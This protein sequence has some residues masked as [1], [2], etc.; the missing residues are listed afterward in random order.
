MIWTRIKQRYENQIFK[1]EKWKPD[2]RI[3]LYHQLT[4]V[5]YGTL[6]EIIANSANILKAS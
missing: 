3:I 4:A 1:P 5:A 2:W 6:K